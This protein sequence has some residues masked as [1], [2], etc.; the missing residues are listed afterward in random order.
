M[1]RNTAISGFWKESHSQAY[2]FYWQH[3]TPGAGPLL[4]SLKSVLLDTWLLWS[5]KRIWK[6]FI[7]ASIVY[8]GWQASVLE[9]LPNSGIAE[10]RQT[11]VDACTFSYTNHR[12]RASVV[13]G[14]RP[15]TCPLPSSWPDGPC[16]PQQHCT[17]DADCLGHYPGHVVKCCRADVCLADRGGTVDGAMP[18]PTMLY[19]FARGGMSPQ[20]VPT[21]ICMQVNNDTVFGYKG[22]PEI[23]R[24][25][26]CS[27]VEFDCFKCQH[28]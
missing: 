10:H 5:E 16:H 24:Q 1:W 14:G 11:C 12:Q 19:R 4:L 27:F 8:R 20:A 7:Y 22:K 18:H 15:A 6:T 21:G 3:T 28:I 26:R 17:T 23:W 25:N 9:V 13:S 2:L